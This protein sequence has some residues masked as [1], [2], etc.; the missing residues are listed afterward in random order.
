[1][2]SDVLI[3]ELKRKFGIKTDRALALRLGMSGIALN[4]WKNRKT[5]LTPR[6]IANAID[7]TAIAAV[8]K[9][10]QSTIKALV[11]FFPVDAVEVGKVERYE[12][13][14]TGKGAGQ[15]YNG[16]R[17]ALETASKGLYVF[18][19]TRGKALYAGQTKKQNIWKEMNLAFNR[20]RS[21]QVMTLVKHPT[22]DVVFRAANEKVRQPTNINLKLHDLAAY[23]SAYEISDGMVDELEALLVRVF[24]N[25]LL[26][27]KME[28]FGKD[29]KKKSKGK[30]AAAS[31]R[32]K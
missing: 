9:S 21:A 19:D 4:H 29:A 15:H 3:A 14:P 22:N 8:R 13:I 20:T 2:K 6:Q 18:Y 32:K 31:K 27:Y 30:S 5:P 7:K 28:K 25:D 23:F 12:V 1:M 17:S 24:P 11:E 26:N 16:L 10:Q